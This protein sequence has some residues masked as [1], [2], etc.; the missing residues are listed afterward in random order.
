MSEVVLLFRSKTTPVNPRKTSAVVVIPK[1]V[2]VLLGLKPGDCI[3][4]LYDKDSGKIFVRRAE[5]EGEDK[6]E[7]SGDLS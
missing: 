5:D 6:T 1:I 3:D 2:A 7:A 4:W